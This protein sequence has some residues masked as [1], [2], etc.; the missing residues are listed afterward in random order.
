MNPKVAIAL[1]ALIVVL[2]VVGVG[3]GAL[4]KDQ[5]VNPGWADTLATLFIKQASADDLVPSGSC[6]RS[7]SSIVVFRGGAAVCT[8]TVVDRRRIKLSAQFSVTLN[9]TQSG[10]GGVQ[11]RKNDNTYEFTLDK[12]TG[13]NPDEF[14]VDCSAPPCTLTVLTG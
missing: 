1:L 2:F 4:P 13:T 14:A 3:C 10:T 8:V 12:P 11:T 5:S 7:G 6:S 9:V